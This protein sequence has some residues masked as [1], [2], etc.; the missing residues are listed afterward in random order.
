MNMTKYLIEESEGVYMKKRKYR[1]IIIPITIMSLF[2]GGFYY[3]IQP[4]HQVVL[5]MNEISQNHEPQSEE[6]PIIQDQRRQISLISIGNSDLYSGLNPMQLWHDYGITAF[7]ISAA[8]QNMKLSFYMFKYALMVQRPKCLL[9]EVDQFFEEREEI[10]SEGYEYTALSYCYPL[11]K[12]S[13]EW[14]KIKDEKFI[15]KEDSKHRLN[16]LGFYDSREV[17]SYHGGFHYMKKSHQREK[18]PRLTQ[19]Y[20]PQ[21]L[22]LAKENNCEVLFVEFPSQTS[23]NYQ[24]YNTVCDIANQYHIPYIDF[25]VRQYHTGFDWKTDSRDGGNHLNY[26]GATKMTKYIGEYLK[27]HYTLE[28]DRKNLEYQDYQEIYNKYRQNFMQ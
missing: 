24:R 3:F 6:N 14:D 2:L 9:L 8:K 25:N 12:K 20:L 16:Y 18:L 27:E 5:E 17:K 11:Y 28:D 23:W 15:K 10:E 21:I 26:Y 22:S 4:K 13:K 7:N 19:K 1:I